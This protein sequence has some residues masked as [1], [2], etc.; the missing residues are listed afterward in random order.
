LPQKSRD[1]G[2]FT[3]PVTIGSLIVGKTLLDFGASINLLPWSML[4]RIGDMEV[5]PTRMTL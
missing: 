5:Q 1:P 2:S 4:K 3:L